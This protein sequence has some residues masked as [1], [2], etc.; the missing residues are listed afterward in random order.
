M[1]AAPSATPLK[2]VL[3]L[4]SV[5]NAQPFFGRLP[6]RVGDRVVAFT[7]KRIEALNATAAEANAPVLDVEILDP[8]KFP[9]VLSLETLEGNPTYYAA[10]DPSTLPEDL[11]ALVKAVEEADAFIICCP[12]YNHTIPPA[13]TA[14][15]NMVGCSKYANKVS[16]SICYSGFPSPAGGARCAVALR[17]FLSELGC[18]PVSKQVIL[19]NA[20]GQLSEAG[21]P[22]G[23]HASGAVKQMDGMLEQLRWWAEACRTQRNK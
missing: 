3:I 21:E 18:L 7:Q 2:A 17:P 5:R 23:E 8:L 13:L 15:M 9:S 4:G 6:P 20:P 11:Q 10:K 14:M 12:E 22:E 16:G 19:P 1:A